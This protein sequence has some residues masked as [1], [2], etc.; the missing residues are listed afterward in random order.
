MRM[1]YVNLGF[2]LWL[3]GALLMPAGC[4]FA[5]P[6][7][8]SSIT[9]EEF[10]P[11]DA[12][13]GV[14]GTSARGYYPLESA[15]DFTPYENRV[16]DNRVRHTFTE[17]GLDFDPDVNA[18]GNTLAFA[19]TRN[20]IHPDIYLKAVDGTAVTQLTNDPADDIQPRFNPDGSRVAFCSNRSGNWD[21][22]IIN[23]D[24]TGLQRITDDLGDSIAPTWSPDGKQLAFTT[25]TRQARRWEIWTLD[26]DQ[27]G[28]RRALTY[29]MFPAWS[30]DGDR[31][32]FQRAR[33]RGSRWFSVWTI[34]LLDGEARFPTEVAHDARA[35]CIA[36]RWSP[37]GDRLVY[38]AAVEGPNSVERAG[39]HAA[40]WVVDLTG[41]KREQLSDGSMPSFNPTWSRTDRVFFV[42]PRN[43]AENIW[44][45]AS[46]A[47]ETRLSDASEP[48]AV[49]AAL[50]QSTAETPVSE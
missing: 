45:V 38:C 37:D 8:T 20:S 28:V 31:I 22:W 4:Q 42:S 18:D 1:R 39:M 30:P 26:V 41:G 47:A 23:S 27:P 44:S 9:H 43:G 46:P 40:L 19:S 7:P 34:D 49:A 48:T 6:H 32:A 16:L 2:A 24:G 35:A 50:R 33:E 17:D 14:A 11:F 3:A 25:W 15:H 36:P 10:G 29:G 5:S 12:A 13:P 21:I